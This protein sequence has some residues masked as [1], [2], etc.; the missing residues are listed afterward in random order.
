MH[1]WKLNAFKTKYVKNVV[2]VCGNK[3]TPVHI[4]TCN[5]MKNIIP[6]LKQNTVQAIFQSSALTY[7]FFVQLER[8]P[9]GKYL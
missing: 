6:V 2:C 8:S 1:R 5:E 9:I 7:D 4:V 3:I